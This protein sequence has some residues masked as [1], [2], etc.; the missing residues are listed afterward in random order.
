MKLSQKQQFL[1]EKNELADKVQDILNSIGEVLIIDYVD[2][3]VSNDIDQVDQEIEEEQHFADNNKA[4]AYKSA[5]DDARRRVK[6]LKNLKKKK[7]QVQKLFSQ[8]LFL[9]KKVDKL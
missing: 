6:Y 5:G 4:G 2:D 7:Q 9:K 8:F 1:N 3:I